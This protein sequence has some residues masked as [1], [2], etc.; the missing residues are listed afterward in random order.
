MN[1][2]KRSKLLDLMHADLITMNGGKNNMRTTLLVSVLFFGAMG[3]L[4]S[5]LFGM[6][7]PMIMGAFFVPMVFNNEMKYHSERMYVVLPIARKDLVRSRFLMSIT[8]FTAASLLFYLLM[9]LSMHLKVYYIFFGEDAEH[10]DVIRLFAESYG[11]TE[12]GMLGLLYSVVFSFGLHLISGNLWKY[13]KDSKDFTAVISGEFRKANKKDKGY[14]L[15]TLVIILFLVLAVTDILPIKSAISPV[16]QLLV[17]LAGAADGFLLGAVMVAM[18][19]F[20]SIY[21]YICT[22]LEYEEKEL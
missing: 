20:F 3:F 17:Q 14:L 4:F 5:P 8:L 19:V 13:F 15:L 7:V 22:I 12:T 16:M 6:Y 9:L 21:S 10:M 18:A 2:N 11:M 1:K